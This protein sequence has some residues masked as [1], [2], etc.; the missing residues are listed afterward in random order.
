[1]NEDGSWTAVWQNQHVDNNLSPR[2]A[3]TVSAQCP[4]SMLCPAAVACIMCC[5]STV[6]R[7]FAF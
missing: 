7:C 6:H 4:Q 5:V 3:E 2:W 1:M